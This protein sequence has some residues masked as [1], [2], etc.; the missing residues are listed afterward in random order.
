[1]N[2]DFEIY[3]QF[4]YKIVKEN[5]NIIEDGYKEF[6]KFMKIDDIWSWLGNE[7]RIKSIST[8][9]LYGYSGNKN[10]IQGKKAAS[11]A[12]LNLNK[13][14]YETNSFPTIQIKTTALSVKTLLGS[15]FHDADAYF[16]V[17]VVGLMLTPTL[18]LLL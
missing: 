4:F 17:V 6:N 3:E 7:N 9:R 10:T 2:S 13:Y 8:Y 11:I 12:H 14:R 15:I 5:N 18:L 16:V 1:M